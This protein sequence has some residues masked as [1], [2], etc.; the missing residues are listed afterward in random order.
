MKDG[1]YRGTAGGEIPD[2]RQAN[3]RRAAGDHDPAATEFPAHASPFA[4][5]PH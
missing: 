4:V 5:R 3:A 1:R 2:R